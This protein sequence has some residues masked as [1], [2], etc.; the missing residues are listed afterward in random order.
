MPDDQVLGSCRSVGCSSIGSNGRTRSSWRRRASA[1]TPPS[2]LVGISTTSAIWPVP[3]PPPPPL[4]PR[5]DADRHLPPQTALRLHLFEMLRAPSRTPTASASADRLCERR[6]D[7][8]LPQ[9]ARRE[10]GLWLVSSGDIDRL[11]SEA[12]L[13]GRARALATP[14]DESSLTPLYAR[15]PEQPTTARGG[16]AAPAAESVL[17]SGRLPSFDCAGEQATAAAGPGRLPPKARELISQEMGCVLRQCALFPP[18]RSRWSRADFLRRELRDSRCH[19]LV[20]DSK[21]EVAKRFKYWRDERDPSQAD[22]VPGGYA[23]RPPLTQTF[24]G[25]EQFFARSAKAAADRRECVYLQHTL[26]QASPQVASGALSPTG[27][28]GGEMARDLSTGFDQSLLG[29][30]AQAGRFGPAA[31]CQLFV[32][33]RCAA[34]ART[35]MHFDQYDNIFMQLAGRKTFLLFDPLQTGKLAP[36]PIHHPLDRS[37]RVGLEA[38]L[39]NADFPR[40][41]TAG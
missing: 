33:G 30:L 9:L 16:T 14:Y 22:R 4:L 15:A 6:T 31:R 11:L 34:G 29:A 1:V 24:M 32:G 37:C 17:C 5:G 10:G 25:G 35:V 20:T 12:K 13:A 8:Q 18:G 21:A 41:S 38:P 23:F 40:A 39:P 36:Y 3:P 2:E 28:V 27:P 7:W 26:L 19:V